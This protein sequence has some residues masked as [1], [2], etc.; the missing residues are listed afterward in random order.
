[1]SG[2]ELWR[3]VDNWLGFYE[4]SDRGRVRSVARIVV[5]SNGQRRRVPGRLLRLSSRARHC[6]LTRP[7]KRQTFY[8]HAIGSRGKEQQP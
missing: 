2:R 8:P 7:G 4:V 3:P 1:M 5:T 6:T